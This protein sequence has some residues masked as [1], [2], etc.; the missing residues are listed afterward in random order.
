MNLGSS[1]TATAVADQHVPVTCGSWSTTGA[2]RFDLTTPVIENSVAC[3]P[4]SFFAVSHEGEW[5]TKIPGSCG[6]QVHVGGLKPGIY[7][8]SLL[9]LDD[10]GQATGSEVSCAAQVSAGLTVDATCV[11]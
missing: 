11:L 6:S 2:V 3:P 10:L 7:F 9:L 8:F 1:C 5:L 4:G